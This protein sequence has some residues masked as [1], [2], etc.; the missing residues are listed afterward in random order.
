MLFRSA[1]SNALA[2][3]ED[4]TGGV[5]SALG[6]AR[7]SLTMNQ[8]KDRGLDAIADQISDSFFSLSDA[9]SSLNR[10]IENLNADP[11]SLNFAQERKALLLSFAKKYGAGDLDE[12]ATRA[13]SAASRMGDLHG[14]DETL[15]QLQSEHSLLFE[16]VKKSLHELSSQRKSAAT[17]L[18]KEVSK[19]LA[20]LSMPNGQFEIRV[21]T[22]EIDE[23]SDIKESGADEVEM[24]FSSHGGNL[25]PISKA[26]SEI[27]RAHV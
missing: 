5:L 19:E 1:S 8:G 2:A 14:G 4:E 18:G 17:L 12:A 20:A 10:Y 7:R 22:E 3:L 13:R 16:Q 6:L 25:L 11:G 23:K 24:L 15:H 26:G 27:G 21:S 9:A